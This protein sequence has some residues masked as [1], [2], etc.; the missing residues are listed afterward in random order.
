MLTTTHGLRTVVIPVTEEDTEAQSWRHRLG[1]TPK[2]GVSKCVLDE[3]IGRKCKAGT[4]VWW[5]VG[6]VVCM[7]FLSPP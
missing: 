4:R 7:C 2:A 6:L 1:F 5:G 3:E